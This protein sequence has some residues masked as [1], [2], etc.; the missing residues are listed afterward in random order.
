MPGTPCSTNQDCGPGFALTCRAPGE[1][2]G[3]GTCRQ[4]TSNCGSDADCA[5]DAG[6][7]GGKLICDPMPSTSCFCSDP[8]ICVAGCRAK[9]DCPSNQGCNRRHQC[10]NSCVPGDGTCP[11]DFSCGA[12][13]FCVQTSCTTDAECSGA[14]VKGFCYSTRGIVRVHP[15]Y[16]HGDPMMTKPFGR[17]FLSLVLSAVVGCSSSGQGS[18]P[19]GG[20]GTGGRGG[21]TAGVGLGR[22][23]IGRQWNVDR[24]RVGL[25]TE[26]AGGTS[27][28]SGGT[29]CRRWR[30]TRR[31]RWRAQAAPEPESPGWAAVGMRRRRRGHRL[32]AGRCARSLMH[33]ERRLRGRRAHDQLL[34]NRRLI[35]L[36]AT[37]AQRFA[38]LESACDASYPR[39]G[40]PLLAPTTDDGST[41]NDAD[42]VSVSCQGGACKTF[43]KA[44]GQPCAAG[45]SCLTCGAPDA[46]VSVCSLRCT[47]DKDCKETAYPTCQFGSD[48]GICTA[49]SLACSGT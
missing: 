32:P 27:S 11:V 34:R 8:F 20:A 6:T 3:C 43:A 16:D 29:A 41:V 14:C 17:V 39:C 31:S 22:C 33:H 36:R 28:G 2:L 18:S 21:G 42:T 45:R 35:G 49:S 12:E 23:R 25:P 5:A 15:R 24:G 7:S 10:Q 37:E 30:G 48:R 19:D 40:C 4:G 47:F 26:G 13:G 38:T 44:C 9:S 46:G 1:F